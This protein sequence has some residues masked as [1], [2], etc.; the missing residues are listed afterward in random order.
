M[1]DL[2]HSVVRMEPK[3]DLYKYDLPDP[4]ALPS[5]VQGPHR[6]RLLHNP[7]PPFFAPPPSAFAV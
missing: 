5:L 3:H 7:F 1:A 4:Q 6:C 2:D